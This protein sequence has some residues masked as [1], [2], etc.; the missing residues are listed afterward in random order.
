M[1]G[2]TDMAKF[3][4]GR[5]LL[6]A[7]LALCPVLALH[8]QGQQPPSPV[9][10]VEARSE[11][12]T[13]ARWVPG[14]VISREDSRIASEVAG[15]LVSIAEV[16]AQLKKAELLA[17]LNDRELQLQV[18]NDDAQVARLSAQLEYLKRQVQRVAKLAQTNTAAV[19]NLDESTAQRDMLEQELKAAQ[20][21][22]DRTQYFIERTRIQAPFDGVVV[23]RLRMPGEFI[24]RGDPVVRLVNTAE[25]EIRVQAP[26]DVVRHVRAGDTVSVTGDRRQAETR[27]RSVVPVGDEVSRMLQLRLVLTGT[28]WIIGEPVRVAVSHGEPAEVVTVPRD[29]VV[30]REGETYVY[31]VTPDNIAHKVVVTLGEGAGNRV[32]IKGDVKVGD[33]VIIRGAER[34]QDGSP[35]TIVGDDAA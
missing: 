31:K 20:V 18:R 15:N 34:L 12:V 13:P 35:I 11:M 24:A 25:L 7:L 28:E 10:V 32:A 27:V 29:S 23:E 16:G 14:T 3:P 30:L 2:G 9:G 26:L 21:A 4:I 6:P 8:A 17:R 19:A 22:R 5:K 33:R 1:N